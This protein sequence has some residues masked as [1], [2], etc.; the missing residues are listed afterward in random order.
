MEKRPFLLICA[1]LYL[2]AVALTSCAH[3]K[4]SSEELFFQ[5]LEQ[6]EAG[7][8]KEAVKSFSLCIMNADAWASVASEQ[9][10]AL[11]SEQPSL[12]VSLDVLR[13]AREYHPVKIA[14]SEEKK[15]YPLTYSAESIASF[16][17]TLIEEMAVYWLSADVDRHAAASLLAQAASLKTDGSWTPC[18]YAGRLYEKAGSSY[19]KDALTFY[20]EA[21]IR[22]TSELTYDRSLWYYLELSRKS[23]PRGTA[24]KLR[25]YAITWHD[26]SYFDDFFDRLAADI[27]SNYDWNTFYRVYQDNNPFM[28]SCIKAKYAYISARLFDTGLI[29]ADNDNFNTS[30]LY[31]TVFENAD[32]GSY[33]DLMAHYITEIPFSIEGTDESARNDF[34][35]RLLD[36]LISHDY[37]ELVSYYLNQFCSSLNVQG[38]RNAYSYLLSKRG[39]ETSYLSLTSLALKTSRERNGIR[40]LL[41]LAFPTYYRTY[42]EAEA[43]QNNL[44][45]WLL[46]A[47]IHSESCFQADISSVVGAQGLTQLMSSTAGDI[48]RKLKISDYDLADAPTNIR[49]GSFY[50]NELIGRLD[51]DIL[52]AAFSYNAG[53]TRV[54]NWKKQAPKMTSDIFLETIPYEETRLYGQKIVRASVM[55]GMLWYGGD[56][57]IINEIMSSL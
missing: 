10:L 30:S 42:V 4:L 14:L 1:V 11:L 25:R 20:D 39:S 32:Y 7:N 18:F 6:K 3:E 52:L 36:G 50:L 26:N 38:I 5:A 53:I 15:D 45:P 57:T 21:R 2:T 35:E 28:S 29:S 17:D 27:L 54:R 55:Y 33:Y 41:T 16:S 9:L 24:E 48:A 31:Q 23:D 49:F 47:L 13:T 8:G 46:F 51:G 12:D 40:D 43:R 22:S 44:E 19:W 37:P 56:L 34:A